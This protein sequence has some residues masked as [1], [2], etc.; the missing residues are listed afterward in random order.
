MRIST[1]G[2]YAVRAMLE[3]T[4]RQNTGPVR[5]SAIAQAQGISRKYLE[6]LLTT[7]RAAGLVQ[8]R[9][10]AGGG[11]MLNRTPDKITI[12]E[13]VALL[14]GSTAP[15]ECVENRRKCRRSGNCA[16]R[17]LW[18]NLKK[19][20]DDNLRGTTLADLARMHAECAHTPSATSIA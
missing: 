11:F 9:R 7:L 16:A 20:I 8:S 12:L 10:G 14:E 1:K 17:Q 18:T 4:L 5:T 15:V 6:Q 2:R 19:S 13:I 3:L